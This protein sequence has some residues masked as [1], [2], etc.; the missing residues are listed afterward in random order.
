MEI[1]STRYF[2]SKLHQ[3]PQ[4]NF[5]VLVFLMTDFPLHGLV[6]TGVG[7][8][9]QLNKFYIKFCGKLGD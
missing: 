8:G 3:T 5:L 1:I 4:S 2:S 6:K 7:V 9:K